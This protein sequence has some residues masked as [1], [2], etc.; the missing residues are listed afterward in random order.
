LFQLLLRQHLSFQALAGRTQVDRAAQSQM[1]QQL[2]L[3][4]E[5]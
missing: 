1:S 2:A 4:V 3:P 5:D